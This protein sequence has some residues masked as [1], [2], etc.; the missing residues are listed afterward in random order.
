MMAYGALQPQLRPVALAP[1]PE[2]LPMSARL[3]RELRLAAQFSAFSAGEDDQQ[4]LLDEACRVA[5]EGLGVT[6]AKVLVYL[7]EERAFVLQAGVGWRDGIVGH[8]RLAVDT[9]TAAGFAWLSGQ[10]IVSNNLVTE[11]RF[12]IPAVLAGH[13]IVSSVNVVVPG[14]GGAA[15]GILEAESPK[16]ADFAAHDL[17]F[18]QLLANTLSAAIS[19]IE[20][21]ALHEEQAARSADEHRA[22]VRELQHRV[23]N[24]LQAISFA[25]GSELRH[26][27]G[28]AQRAAFARLSRRV[29]AI[30]GL[31]E[32]L[33]GSRMDGD[34]DIGA[35]LRSL[36]V[37]IADAADL[38]SRSIKLSVDA[39]PLAIPVGRALPIA[40]AVNELVA[41]AAEHAFPRGRAGRITVQVLAKGTD[42]A[43]RPVVT[44]ADDGCGFLGKQPGSAGLGFVERLVRQAGGVLARED[45]AGTRWH[46]E[47]AS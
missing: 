10:S 46:M 8:A 19:R 3:W 28:P 1:D 23:R 7:P 5:A 6:L 44:V 30:A 12:G 40:V 20:R 41:N 25:I 2:Q 45:G 17:C 32:H 33:L 22:S 47:I 34:V 37:R 15:F 42:G 21:Q 13:G 4:S 9:I 16:P 43:G 14:I 31:Y 36:C 38:K 27:V 35:F 11:G 29:M 39:Q 26:A 24:D 18:L